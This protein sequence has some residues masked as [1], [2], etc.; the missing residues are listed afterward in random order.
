M[1]RVGGV[2]NGKSEYEPLPRVRVGLRIRVRVGC[3]LMLV[4]PVI[5]RV[6]L[7]RF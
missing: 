1:V 2:K 4:W 6:V 7:G 5:L 3:P